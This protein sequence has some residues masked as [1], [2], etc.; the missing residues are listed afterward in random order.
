MPKLSGYATAL[1][2]FR[3]LA[4]QG[5]DYAQFN[6]GQLYVSGKGA[7]QD[8]ATAASWY[9]KA[10]DRERHL[11]AAAWRTLDIGLQS[12]AIAS[13]PSTR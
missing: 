12:S 7:P 2:L 3:P 10:A 6:V 4:E 9:R 1:R 13:W 8:Y 11:R 5:D